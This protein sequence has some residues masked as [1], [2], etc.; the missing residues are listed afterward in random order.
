MRIFGKFLVKKWT[1]L[2]CIQNYFV[3]NK[4]KKKGCGEE[5]LC[6]GSIFSVYCIVIAMVVN[7][8]IKWSSETSEPKVCGF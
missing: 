8:K 1:G 5:V 6:E 2:Y 7:C 3:I 4:L